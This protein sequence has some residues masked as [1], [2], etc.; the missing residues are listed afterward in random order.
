LAYL[1]GHDAV[2]LSAFGCGAYKNPSY[3]VAKIMKEVINEYDGLFEVIYI[4][5]L[6][7]FNCNGYIVKRFDKYDNLKIFKD[8]FKC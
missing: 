5:I 8:V 2:V 6:A 7:N 1:Y 3:A 4:A